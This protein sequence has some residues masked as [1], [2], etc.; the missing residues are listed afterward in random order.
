M[1]FGDTHKYN[2]V[3]ACAASPGPAR[4]AGGSRLRERG[5]R[6]AERRLTK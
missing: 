1:K 2:R 6:A 5:A 4:E 3:D